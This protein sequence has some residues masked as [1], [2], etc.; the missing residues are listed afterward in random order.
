MALK[1]TALG[2]LP[3]VDIS[4]QAFGGEH[5]AVVGYQDIRYQDALAN[6]GNLQTFLSKFEDNHGRRLNPSLIVKS[7]AYPGRPNSEAISSFMDIVA[8]CVVLDA[9][10]RAVTWRR[11]VG[12]F[13]TDSFE[14][15]PWMIDREGQKFLRRTLPFGLCTNSTSSGE[16]LRRPSQSRRSR[17]SPRILGFLSN[18]TLSGRHVSSVVK[19]IGHGALFFVR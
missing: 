7:D 10:V 8:A 6:T 19:G 5:L 4:S 11:N 3:N 1:W 16:P 2:V 12:P 15:Y 18:F 17:M 13:Y 14:I 9:R